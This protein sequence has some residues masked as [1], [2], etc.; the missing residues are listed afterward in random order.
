VVL[1]RGLQRSGREQRLVVVEPDEAVA[2]V[3]EEAAVDRLDRRIDD[4]DAE[5]EQ[6]GGEEAERERVFA[7]APGSSG[8][9]RR[10]GGRFRRDA[11][12]YARTI[13]RSCRP[14]SP[15]TRAPTPFR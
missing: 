1:D 15:P 6:G 9:R 10:L 3:A 12:H 7:P 5:E 8:V 13:I 14:S 4:P 11:C 2:A